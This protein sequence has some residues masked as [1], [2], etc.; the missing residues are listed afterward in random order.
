MGYQIWCMKKSLHYLC[1]FFQWV[2]GNTK[3]QWRK[4]AVW[5]FWKS[6]G[7][8]N[9]LEEVIPSGKWTNRTFVENVCFFFFLYFLVSFASEALTW[10]FEPGTCSFL[11]LLWKNQIADSAKISPAGLF[12]VN[13]W[14]R[15]CPASMKP[16]C[17]Q[18]LI[19]F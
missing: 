16:Y 2:R 8:I 7:V 13:V 19:D 4:L 6:L 18:N 11:H 5:N 3:F 12:F 1:I 15:M 17:L 10:R 9:S 14:R